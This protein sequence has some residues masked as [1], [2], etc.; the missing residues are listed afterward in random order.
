MEQ[1][2]NVLSRFVRSRVPV[3]RCDLCAKEV[4]SGHPHLLEPASRQIHC[5]CDACA[6]LFSN[7]GD[8]RYKR[9][10][11]DIKYLRDFRLTDLQWGSLMLPIQLAFFFHSTPD[12]RLIALYPS[13][14]GATE[15][16]LPL[17]AWGEIAAENP[18]LRSL[19]PDVEAL[20]VNRVGEKREYFIAPIDECYKL[21]GL[22]RAKW[23]G[24]SGG[25]EAWASINGFFTE[26]KDRSVAAK[27][28]ANA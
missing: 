2:Y 4:A 20:L 9:V 11:R 14:A 6:I 12:D 10:P 18:E 13:P 27:E 8:S 24:L 15:S 22:I 3:E 21:V 5:A 28:V 26:L 7:Q 23:H 1:T 17:D 19:R 16:T 25:T